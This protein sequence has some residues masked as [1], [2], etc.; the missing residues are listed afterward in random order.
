MNRFFVFQKIIE[1]GS[2]TKAAKE[3]GYTQSAIS[4]TVANLEKEFNLAL[5]KRSRKGINLTPAGQK[6]YPE[7]QK[8]TRQYFDMKEMAD[9]LKGLETGTVRIGAS[10]SISRYWLPNLIKG[11][12]DQ[13]PQVHFTLYQGD[14]DEIKADILAG[15]VDFGFLKQTLNGGLKT[16]PLK[17]ERLLAVMAAS[18]PLAQQKIVSL[19]DLTQQ[20]HNI[21]LI[22]EGSHSDV[23]LAFD[24][25][26]VNPHIKDQIQDDYTV[27]A[28]VEAGLGVSLV[29][30]L[31]VGNSDFKIAHAATV[32]E[33][34]QSIEI[35]YL[36]Q[37]N[38]SIASKNF[39]NYVVARKEQLP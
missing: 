18:H 22:P 35:A 10:N 25:I 39:I 2:F 30:E 34:V 7:F 37:S 17:K 15:R 9:H 20:S 33:I 28:M 6:L 4:Q 29:S 11:F 8:I 31:M 16:I 12:E 24:Q 21:I 26:G 36:N 23:T 1:T 14:Y 13:Y 19:Q 38:L 3:L 5:L 27:M 32:P